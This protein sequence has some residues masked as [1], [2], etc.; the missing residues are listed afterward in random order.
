MFVSMLTTCPDN[1]LRG[2]LCRTAATDSRA[3]NYTSTN[4][5][6]ALNHNIDTTPV[7]QMFV[8]GDIVHDTVKMEVHMVL[9]VALQSEQIHAG[10][11]RMSCPSTRTHSAQRCRCELCTMWQCQHTRSV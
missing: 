4:I 8:L 5:V 1:G 7:L 9:G 2:F 6:H 3:T 11:Y 10:Q